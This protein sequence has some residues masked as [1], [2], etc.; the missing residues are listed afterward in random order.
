VMLPSRFVVTLVAGVPPKLTWVVPAG[1]RP[2]TIA[3]RTEAPPPAE[4][5]SPLPVM[6]TW[7]P[8]DAGPEEGLTAL[9]TGLGMAMNRSAVPMA[10]VPPGAVVERISSGCS[11][12]E[13]GSLSEGAKAP[14]QN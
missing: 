3:P 6:V 13:P 7:V 1:P 10:V 4:L 9:M 8:P 14:N 2:A 5:V 12:A 11:D